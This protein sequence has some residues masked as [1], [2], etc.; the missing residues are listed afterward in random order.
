MQSG[1]GGWNKGGGPLFVVLANVRVHDLFMLR[2]FLGSSAN[3]M[4]MRARERRDLSLARR[5][6]LQPHETERKHHPHA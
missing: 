2:L 5:K 4:A 6:I 3:A 1:T